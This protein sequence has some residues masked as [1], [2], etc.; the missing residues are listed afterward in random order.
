M[1]HQ[2]PSTPHVSFAG[3]ASIDGQSLFASVDLQ[4]EAGLWTC[5][6]G[7]SGIGKT[8]ILRLIAGLST[9]IE[10]AGQV[11]ASD[12]RPVHTITTYM[13]QQDQLLSW[14][15]VM[16]NVTIG[17]R[18]RGEPVDDGRCRQL[19]GRVGLA[20]RENAKPY[21]LSGGQRQRVA[22]ARTLAENQPVVL[23]DEPFSALDVR[24]RSQMQDLAFELLAG[25][26]VL[27]VTHD[28]LEAARLGQRIYVLNEH[29]LKTVTP[30]KSG[31]PRDVDDRAMLAVQGG[32]HRALMR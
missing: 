24:T 13:G 9:D 27:H 3:A 15:S 14:A 11:S 5:L 4:I 22:L 30:P 32:L 10:F 21:Q 7:P 26:T 23:L 18:L 17:S 6:L 28:P 12:G 8:S 20:A 19:I 25:R 16:S 1:D 29:G 2:H 31:A